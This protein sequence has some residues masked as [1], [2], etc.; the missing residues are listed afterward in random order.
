MAAYQPL[1]L[2][3]KRNTYNLAAYQSYN[4]VKKETPKTCNTQFSLSI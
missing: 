1:H 2:H 4:L 3:Q